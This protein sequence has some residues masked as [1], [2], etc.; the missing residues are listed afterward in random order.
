MFCLSAI[1]A[2]SNDYDI[3]GTWVS[4]EEDSIS[5]YVRVQTFYE[6]NVWKANDTVFFYGPK[7]THSMPITS[8]GTWEQNGDLVSILMNS[9]KAE[10]AT[11]S[12]E[13]DAEKQ[14]FKITESSSKRIKWF[15]IRDTDKKIVV[16]NKKEN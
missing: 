7:G 2:C 15:N 12:V 5:K 3:K 1:F 8:T 11:A 9:I 14:S 16:L 4:I 6:D 10:H 13:N